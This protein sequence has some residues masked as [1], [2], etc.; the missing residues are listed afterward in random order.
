MSTINPTIQV[1]TPWHKEGASQKQ[2]GMKGKEVA[3]R[4]KFIGGS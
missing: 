4:T 3:A 1:L 2:N